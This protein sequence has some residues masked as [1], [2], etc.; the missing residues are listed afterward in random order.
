MDEVLSK[1]KDFAD[2]SH[3]EQMRKYTPDRYIVH[4]VRVMELCHQYND[5]ISVLAAALLHDVLEDTAVSRQ[6]IKNFLSGLMNHAEV[7]KTLK[8][9]EELTDVYV[10]AD[11][12]KLNR[13]M[14]KAKEMARLENTSAEAQT[15][16]YADIIDNAREIVSHDANFGEVFI[17]ECSA[18]LKK[19][20]KGNKQL[21][22]MAEATLKRAFEELKEKKINKRVL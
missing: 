6:E 21:Y 17:R 13:R 12:P 19:I 22:T 9:V 5:D 3:G 2:R 4:P 8:L 15:I 10:K 16:K 18:L 7:E 1:I 20:D 14:R 11:Y